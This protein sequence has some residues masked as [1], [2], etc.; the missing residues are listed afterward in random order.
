MDYVIE[1]PMLKALLASFDRVQ[2]RYN[3]ILSKIATPD[4]T[5][6]DLHD[7]VCAH[8]RLRRCIAASIP[9]CLTADVRKRVDSLV[10]ASPALEEVVGIQELDELV[11]LVEQ[12]QV[13]REKTVARHLCSEAGCENKVPIGLG[14]WLNLQSDLDTVALISQ[15]ITCSACL[16]RLCDEDNPEKKFAI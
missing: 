7:F 9:A 14:A 6:D 5:E 16:E 4:V 2:D 15:N 12:C 1:K 10:A 3:S 13:L 11:E 8:S